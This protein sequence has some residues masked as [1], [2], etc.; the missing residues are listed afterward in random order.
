MEMV[1]KVKLNGNVVCVYQQF[2]NDDYYCT[3]Y[4][5]VG[6]KKYFLDDFDS[7]TEATNFALQYCFDN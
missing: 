3:V 5:I 7:L 6:K 4:L 1:V 2:L